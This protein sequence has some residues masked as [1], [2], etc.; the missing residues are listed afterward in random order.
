VPSLSVFLVADTNH[1]SLDQAK[2]IAQVFRDHFR[3]ETAHRLETQSSQFFPEK[4]FG[5]LSPAEIPPISLEQ[6]APKLPAEI[7]ISNNRSTGPLVEAVTAAFSKIGTRV[8]FVGLDT[9]EPIHYMFTGQG[10]NTDYPE[11]EL[12]LDTV[13]PYADFN[14]TN[15]IKRLVNLATHEANDTKRSEIIKSVGKEF[16]SSGKIVPLTVR[17]YVH[18]YQPSR[19]D[20]NNVTTYDGDIPLYQLKVLE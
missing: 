1:L 7:V 15:E 6:N 18:L 8:R 20:L 19:V 12:H 2:Y 5:S 9:K 16:L 17:A 4:T 11:I 14:A 13:G 10:M 3:Y